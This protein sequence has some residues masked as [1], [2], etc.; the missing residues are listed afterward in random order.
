VGGGGGENYH[1][2]WAQNQQDE[3]LEAL[4]QASTFNP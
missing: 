1:N 3:C 4:N 2:V